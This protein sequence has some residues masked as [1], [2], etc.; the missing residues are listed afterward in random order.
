MVQA[1][2]MVETASGASEGVVESLKGV[3]T[4][5]EANVVAG[6]YDVI[7]EIETTEVHEV[8]ETVSGVVGGLEGVLDTKTYVA[9]GA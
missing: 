3:D 5:I 4:V 6:D 2:T 1:F 9:L 7:V 8:F